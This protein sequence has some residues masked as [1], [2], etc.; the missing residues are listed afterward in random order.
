ML[1]VIII[2]DAQVALA[3]QAMF[4]SAIKLNTNIY[5]QVDENALMQSKLRI[6]QRT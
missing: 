5:A 3:A 6:P 1:L 4:N 2:S